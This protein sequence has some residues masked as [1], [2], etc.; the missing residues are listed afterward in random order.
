MSPTHLLLWKLC[1]AARLE[2]TDGES[3]VPLLMIR[4]LLSKQICPGRGWA[5]TWHGHPGRDR[6][7]P[8]KPCPESGE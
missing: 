8:C 3:L 7:G 4:G 5:G 2:Q 1:L 6:L